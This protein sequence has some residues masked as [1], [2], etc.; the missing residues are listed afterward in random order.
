MSAPQTW[1]ATAAEL[2]RKLASAVEF[3][4]LES[5]ERYALELL[6]VVRAEA[7]RRERSA[8]RKRGRA[9]WRP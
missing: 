2:K 8:A 3:G 5:A 9:G 4:Q 1:Y 7:K 6:A